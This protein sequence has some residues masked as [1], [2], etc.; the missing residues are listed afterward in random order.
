MNEKQ[1]NLI[2]L[3]CGKHVYVEQK[4]I[5]RSAKF[6]SLSCSAK[7]GHK[8]RDN[9]QRGES[10]PNWKGGISKNN[11][12]Y[13]KLQVERY[14]ERISARQKVSYEIRRGNIV[15]E[16]CEKCGCKTDVHA[17]HDDY[18]KPLDIRWLCSKH[19]REAHKHE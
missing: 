11:Y 17:H 8:L 1:P 12:H 7:H 9:S 16:S 2:C 4:Y 19:H 5:N 15:R 18:N 6:C 14:P 3:Q 13:K 10:N